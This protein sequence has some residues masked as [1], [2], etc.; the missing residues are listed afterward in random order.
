[1][2]AAVSVAINTPAERYSLALQLL[3]HHPYCRQ[4]ESALVV[5]A[6]DIPF[7]RTAGVLLFL[8]IGVA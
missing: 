1:M 6:Y 3:G 7:T 4:A 5:V 8:F 2:V